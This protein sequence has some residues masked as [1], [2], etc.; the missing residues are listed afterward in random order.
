MFGDGGEKVKKALE[1]QSQHVE[2]IWLWWDSS[3]SRWP[4]WPCA[5]RGMMY[6]GNGVKQEHSKS[7]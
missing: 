5:R 3:R 2:M 1:Y 7:I 4:A 6:R